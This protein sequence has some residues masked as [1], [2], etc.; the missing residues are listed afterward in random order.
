MPPLAWLGAPLEGAYGKLLTDG[1]GTPFSKALRRLA[2]EA[3]I[4][5]AA[6]LPVGCS[7]LKRPF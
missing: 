4:V 5:F 3:S 1:H 2:G 7:A 6:P